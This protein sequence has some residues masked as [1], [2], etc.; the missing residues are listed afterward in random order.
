MIKERVKQI[1]EAEQLSS[2]KFADAIGVQRSSISHILSGRNKPSLDVV[3]R[4][5]EA[6]TKLNINWLMLGNGNM[7]IDD[8]EKVLFAEEKKHSEENEVKKIEE[9]NVTPTPPLNSTKEKEKQDKLKL[10]PTEILEVKTDDKS[11][12]KVIE[13]NK[14]SS[15]QEQISTESKQEN[16]QFISPT[17]EKII[18]FTSDR[19]F[20]EYTPG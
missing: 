5:L 17:T 10:E 15:G 14:N 3:T 1:I 20:I 13:K 6:F 8:T 11:E 19:K 18:L 16:V 2:S 9:N 4:I 7:Y 12:E